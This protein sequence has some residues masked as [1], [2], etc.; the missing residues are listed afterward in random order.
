MTYTIEFVC[1]DRGGHDP[2]TIDTL[3]IEGDFGNPAD[4]AAAR[5]A[6]TVYGSHTEWPCGKCPR[7]PRLRG[8]RLTKL[9][10]HLLTRVHGEQRRVVLDVS[11]LG[12]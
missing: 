4:V 12:I 2:Y 11:M 5:R 9:A 3:E 7:T 8:Q 10:D 1:T 6:L